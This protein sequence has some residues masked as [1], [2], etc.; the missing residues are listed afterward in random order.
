MSKIKDISGIKHNRLTAI[1]FVKRENNNT[2]WLFKCDCGNER[3][4]IPNS[5]FSGNTKSCGCLNQELRRKRQLKHDMCGKHR[6]YSIWSGM[7]QR[8][9][10]KKSH[11]YESYGGRGITICQEWREDFINFYNWANS[12]GYKDDLTLDRIDNDGNYEPQNCRWA[13][14]E[15]QSEN[16][17]PRKS[18]YFNFERRNFSQFAKEN[19]IK[20]STLIN[21]LNRGMSIEEALSTPIKKTGIACAM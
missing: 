4:L 10:Y 2:Y 17:R 12:H 14:I 1:R 7:K 21:R 20:R 15:Q 13:T 16:K 18:K 8:C 5:V 6:L 19:G 11:K 3:V 9:F